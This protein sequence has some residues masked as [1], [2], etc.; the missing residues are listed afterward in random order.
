MGE[1][2]ARK[3]SPLLKDDLGSWACDDKIVLL[4]FLLGRAEWSVNDQY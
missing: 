4:Q 3:I 2:Y 1:T